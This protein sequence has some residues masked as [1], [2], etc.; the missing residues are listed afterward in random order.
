MTEIMRHI[1]ETHGDTICHK[2]LKNQ[3]SRNIRCMFIHPVLGVLPV[4][5]KNS[6]HIRASGGQGGQ[7]PGQPDATIAGIQSTAD[8]SCNNISDVPINASS[9]KPSCNNV[10][11]HF[12]KH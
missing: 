8:N 5:K 12:S 9:Y 7:G 2:F 6:H 1:K 10:S 3:C 11:K 4:E